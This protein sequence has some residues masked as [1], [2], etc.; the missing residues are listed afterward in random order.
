[1]EARKNCF[2]KQ[3]LDLFKGRDLLKA[4]GR[5][6]TDSTNIIASVR[7]LNRLELVGETLLHALNEITQVDPVWLKAQVTPDWFER[8]ASRFSNYR[9]PKSKDKRQAL[10][11]VIALLGISKYNGWELR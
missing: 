5:Q 3:M 2:F 7:A 1:M 8:Y 9:L 4:G 6:R 10:A 11:E